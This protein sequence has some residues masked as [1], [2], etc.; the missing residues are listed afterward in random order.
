MVRAT[1]HLSAH[2]HLAANPEFSSFAVL[3]H[4]VESELPALTG[5]RTELVVS[6]LG[7]NP[8]PACGPERALCPA[9]PLPFGGR[10]PGP[11]RLVRSPASSPL[12]PPAR[13]EG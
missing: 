3:D 5:L 12:S 9:H 7:S 13:G 10:R 1:D 11:L 2:A 8:S 6:S 4:L